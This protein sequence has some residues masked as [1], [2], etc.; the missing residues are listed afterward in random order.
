MGPAGGHPHTGGDA[1]CSRSVK[2]GMVLDLA[3]NVFRCYQGA[4]KVG[5]GEQ[6]DKF[7]AAVAGNQVGLPDDPLDQGR[8]FLE[9]VIA[10]GMTVGIVDPFEM[11]EIEENA[12]DVGSRPFG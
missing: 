9:D 1:D 2:K 5:V 12:G 3:A 7:F 4:R 11:I 8:R 10:A 6:N